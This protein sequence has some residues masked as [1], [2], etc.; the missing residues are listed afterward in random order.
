MRLRGIKGSRNVEVRGRGRAGAAGGI[1]VVGLLVVLAVGYFT[2]IDVTPLLQGADQQQTQQ[3]APVQPADPEGTQFASQVLATT[4][5]V[6]TQIFAEQ[7]GREYTPPVLVVFDG[8]TQSPCGGASGAT[9]PFYCPVDQKAYLDTAFFDMLSQRLG[10]DGDFAVAY[11][12]AHEVAHHVQNQLGILEQVN[13]ARQRGSVTEA[14]ALT[15]RLELMADCFSGVW[16]QSVRGLMERGDLEEALNAARKIGDDYLQRQAGQVP[17]PHTFT[18]GTS[19]QRS[20][21]FQRGYDSGQ[22]DQCD[23]FAAQKL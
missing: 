2:G 8:V 18:H 3:G 19:E 6:W 12:I 10:A 5:Q 15:V 23:T 21:W 22:I 7:V 20:S 16:A 4:E 17:Q 1:G 13:A 11:V 14:N 9:G